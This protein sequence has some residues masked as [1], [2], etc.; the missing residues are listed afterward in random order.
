QFKPAPNLL[1]KF[2]DDTTV[3]GLISNDDETDYR[4]EARHGQKKE[5]EERRGEEESSSSSSADGDLKRR[6]RRGAGV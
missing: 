5:S 4:T 1:I 6:R 3:V 2:A